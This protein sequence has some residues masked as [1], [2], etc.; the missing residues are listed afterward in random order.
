MTALRRALAALLLLLRWLTGTLRQRRMRS[1]RTGQNRTARRL[2]IRERLARTGEN[3]SRTRS[4]WHAHVLCPERNIPRWRRRRRARNARRWRTRRGMRR[5]GLNRRGWAR[6]R[7]PY[8]RRRLRRGRR[9][10]R[11][12]SGHTRLSRKCGPDMCRWQWRSRRW[13]NR[14]SWNSRNSGSGRHG[15]RGRRS[16]RG[17]HNGCGRRRRRRR[18]RD[19]HDRCYGSAGPCGRRRWGGSRSRR[20]R[21]RWRD[22]NGMTGSLHRSGDRWSWRRRVHRGSR[23]NRDR[24]RRKAGWPV[25]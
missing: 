20:T 18:H 4:G 6:M 23:R 17:G 25:R 14:G 5:S 10:R 16:R 8:G 1:R 22:G 9:P 12:G 13:S 11:R 3:R 15:R 2:S 19:V 24:G 7:Q 21:D